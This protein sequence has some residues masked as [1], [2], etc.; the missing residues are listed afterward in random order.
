MY[1]RVRRCKKMYAKGKKLL[2]MEMKPED[3]RQQPPLYQTCDPINI[4]CILATL[5]LFV[6]AKH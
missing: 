5:S 6:I 3:I 2:M 4:E 1:N